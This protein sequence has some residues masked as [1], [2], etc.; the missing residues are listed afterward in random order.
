MTDEKETKKQEKLVEVTEVIT[1]T[2]E[3]L[4][5]PNGEVVSTNAYLAWLGNTILEIKKAVA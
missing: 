5:L 1:Q 2:S 3:A 4:K